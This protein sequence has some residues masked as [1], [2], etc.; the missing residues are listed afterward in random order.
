[1]SYKKQVF[2]HLTSLLL[3]FELIKSQNVS[4][5]PLGIL[6]ACHQVKNVQDAQ[7][8]SAFRL[9][10]TCLKCK[11]FHLFHLSN[12]SDAFYVVV[13]VFNLQRKNKTRF[14]L[15]SKEITNLSTGLPL[16]NTPERKRP[17]AQLFALSC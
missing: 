6:N 1:M 12:T 4:L 5:V 13:F 7:K 14:S 8:M 17:I 15:L 11:L 16:F 9:G 10:L 2:L 3:A